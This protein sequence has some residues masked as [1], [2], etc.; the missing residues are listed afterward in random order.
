MA[1]EIIDPRASSRSPLSE[2]EARVRA[3]GA[4]IFCP[5]TLADAGISDKAVVLVDASGGRIGFRAPVEG[6]ERLAMSVRRADTNKVA[7]SKDLLIRA[8]QAFKR[9]AWELTKKSKHA[10]VKKVYVRQAGRDGSPAL[11]IVEIIPGAGVED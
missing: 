2:S 9:S 3:D 4:I 11:V 10:G 6:E 8:H 5:K 7:T 1:W